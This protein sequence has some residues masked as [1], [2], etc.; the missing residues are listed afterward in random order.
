MLSVCVCV[1]VW[2]FTR[3][4]QIV[5]TET[6]NFACTDLLMNPHHTPK[7]RLVW[8]TLQVKFGC[9]KKSAW[10]GIFNQLSIAAHGMLVHMWLAV[11]LWWHFA[12]LHG[13]LRMLQWN[14]P[15]YH[16]AEEENAEE[17]EHSSFDNANACFTV[18]CLLCCTEGN[19]GS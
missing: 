16:F 1:C 9:W 6:C 8:P 2:M 14:W 13:S 7:T 17:V 12:T 3:V 19:I 15:S 10:I 4:A 11:C 18:C 5:T